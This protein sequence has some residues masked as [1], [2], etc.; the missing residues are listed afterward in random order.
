MNLYPDLRVTDHRA[1]EILVAVDVE[2]AQPAVTVADDAITGFGNGARNLS[3]GRN[4]E[5]RQDKRG[6]HSMEAVH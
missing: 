1:T 6:Y 4:G 3:L 5:E 2:V